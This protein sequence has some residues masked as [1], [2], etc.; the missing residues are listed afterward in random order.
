MLRILH[1]LFLTVTLLP[2]WLV[3]V[4]LWTWP[5]N[6]ASSGFEHESNSVVSSI[7][8]E[9][10]V[11]LF[12]SFLLSF[13]SVGFL[14]LSFCDLFFSSWIINL[15]LR[16]CWIRDNDLRNSKFSWWPSPHHL[17][18][19]EYYEYFKEYIPITFFTGITH[20]CIEKIART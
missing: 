20:V 13:V 19:S 14:F 3:L 17:E 15:D 2:A 8:N 4:I 11:L 16:N 9:P 10:S 12:F 1:Q 18:N 7:H 5:A 6:S